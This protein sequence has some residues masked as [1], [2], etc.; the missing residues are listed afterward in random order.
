MKRFMCFTCVLLLLVMVLSVPT[1]ATEAIGPKASSFFGK[2]SV[3]LCNV[4]GPAFE[5]WFDVTGT[6]TM[7]AI[8]ANFIK[9]Q[10]SSD[11][12]NWTTLSTFSKE[13]YPNLIGYSSVGHE[14]GVRYV[15]TAG[16]YY[17]AYIQLYAKN[18]SGYGT[19]DRYTS[20]I[21]IPAS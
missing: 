12:V 14:A 11:G 16:H 20:A 7:E 18:S 1:F 21:Y 9:I 5:A 6:G 15:G 2:S 8:G 10:R 4:S 3:Y 13:S 17:R 19:W